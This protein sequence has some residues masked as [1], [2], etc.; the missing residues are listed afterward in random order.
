M[1]EALMIQSTSLIPISW[2][3][4]IPHKD[5]ADPNHNTQTIHWSSPSSLLRSYLHNKLL[6]SKSFVSCSHTWYSSPLGSFVEL[7]F[8]FY[9][10]HY[11]HTY[12]HCVFFNLSPGLDCYIHKNQNLF[13]SLMYPK[14]PAQLLAHGRF[15]FCVS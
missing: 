4:N 2:Q 6:K 10:L 9:I 14:C 3:S 8:T 15:Y 12:F 7:F 1:I 5:I 11:W 13:Y